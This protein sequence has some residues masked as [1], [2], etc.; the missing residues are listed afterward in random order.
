MLIKI[1]I[2]KAALSD[3]TAQQSPSRALRF[4][5]HAVLVPVPGAATA[6]AH[7]IVPPSVAL[8]VV[9]CCLEL[10]EVGPVVAVM[11]RSATAKAA[12]GSHAVSV[13]LGLRCTGAGSAVRSCVEP[14]VCG[15]CGDGY[16]VMSCSVP[17]S[18]CLESD[19]TQ[20]TMTTGAWFH[21]Q[22]PVL[23]KIIAGCDYFL[24]KKNWWMRWRILEKIASLKW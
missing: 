2:N 21:D 19:T 10:P 24:T 9:R 17:D 1:T 16:D 14:C 13:V 4:L 20:V 3:T 18:P 6:L 11:P 7:C 12:V 23:Q 5:S 8:P 15:S 22:R